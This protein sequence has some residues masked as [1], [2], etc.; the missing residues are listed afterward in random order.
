MVE[1]G[2]FLSR[3]VQL[4]N[5]VIKERMPCEFKPTEYARKQIVKVIIILVNVAG[6]FTDTFATCVR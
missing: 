3:R 4:F 2:D 6:H 1:F 5:S